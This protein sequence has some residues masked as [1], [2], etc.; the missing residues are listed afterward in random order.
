MSNIQALFKSLEDIMRN[1]ISKLTVNDAFQEITNLLLLRLIE[2]KIIDGSINSILNQDNIA[3]DDHCIFS[4]I[5]NKYC[6][7]Y[8]KKIKERIIKFGELYDLLFNENRHLNRYFDETLDAFIEKEDDEDYNNMCVF[9]KIYHHKSLSEIYKTSW[10]KYFK[11]EKKD[12]SDIVNCMVKI[13]ETFNSIDFINNDRDILGDAFEKYRDGVF[14]IKSGLGQYFTNQFIIQKILEE[15]DLKPSDKQFDPACGAGGFFIKSRSYIKNKYG[16]EEADRYCQNI[17]G[18]EVDPNIFKVLQLNSYI[19][20]FKLDNFKL[21]DSM[22]SS[23]NIS[24][25]D[26]LTYNPPFGASFDISNKEIFPIEIKNSSGLFLQLGFKALKA[27]GRCGVVVD[28]GIINNGSDKKTTW[29]S[30]LRKELLN[31]GLKKIIL[32]PNGSFQYASTFAMCILIYDKTYKDQK[33]IYEEGYFKKEDKGNRIKPMYF[34]NIGEVTYEDIKKN[35]YSL[36]YDDYF[37]VKEEKKAGWIKLGDVCE[38]V[39]GK[40]L[41]NSSLK[42]GIYPVIGAGRSPMGY[43]NEYNRDEECILISSSGSYAGYISR[44]ITKVWAS[45]CFSV[46]SKITNLDENFLY[47]YLKLNQENIYKLQHGNGQP[48]VNIN[49]MI[50]FQIPN[51]PLSHQT[52]IVEFLDNYFMTHNLDEFISYLGKFDIFSLLITKKYRLFDELQSY[53]NMIKILEEKINI[54]DW[55]FETKKKYLKIV[56]TG[57]N[58]IATYNNNESIELLNELFNEMVLKMIQLE[59]IPR[60][61]N[62]YIRSLFNTVKT[63]C[64]M[65]K[66]GEIIKYLPKKLKLKASDGKTEGRYKFYCSSQTKI[67]FYDSYEFDEKCILLG[68]GG[69]PSVHIDEKFCISH[70]DVYVI[71]PKY[72]NINI[73]YLYLYLI[74][75]KHLMI[76]TGNGL[77]H[78]SKQNIDNIVIPIPPLQIQESIINKIVQLNEQSSHYEQYSKTL[79]TELELMNETISNLTLYSEEIRSDNPIETIRNNNIYDDTDKLIKSIKTKNIKIKKV[80]CEVMDV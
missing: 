5:Y 29:Q 73:D 70:D 21:I 33:I 23:Y 69:L 50:D 15:V 78:L 27:D 55:K 49:D 52:E 54:Q 32:L 41:T 56:S 74:N 36:K 14:G 71:K 30:K 9:K 62:A 48:H 60:N 68:R 38:L 37:K 3:I 57:Y 61:K 47:Y 25:Y 20:G 42:E 26:V 59:N 22:K 6:I 67:M 75:N 12:E 80:E 18:H 17:Y 34:N 39:R 64:K 63:K 4:T 35:N 19:Y 79:Q 65:M 7:D 2:P 1:G 28:Q 72:D 40:I 43:H 10:K 24:K 11:F 45:D 46:K 66:L 58:I 13:N 76:F 51:L 31:N 8:D 53:I 77:K 44:Y 16:I